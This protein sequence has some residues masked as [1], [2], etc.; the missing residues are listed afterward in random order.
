MNRKEAIDI[1]KKCIKD[2]PII[3]ANGFGFLPLASAKLCT[4]A[5][6]SL[7]ALFLA[8]PFLISLPKPMGVAAPILV[9]GAIKRR[10]A[11]LAI[12]APALVAE[13]ASGET[14]TTE[15]IE[16]APIRVKMSL[17]VLTSP[18]GVFIFIRIKS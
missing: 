16:L 5:T 15:G 14:Q 17:V 8:S 2:D 10:C 6:K 7:I 9:P 13:A 4:S 1:I 3:S 18:P 11:P 12:I